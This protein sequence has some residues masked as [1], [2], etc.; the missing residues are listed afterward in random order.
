MESGDKKG[1]IQMELSREKGI[2]GKEEGRGRG[3]DAEK[4]ME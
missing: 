2:S 4:W 3:R 1:V